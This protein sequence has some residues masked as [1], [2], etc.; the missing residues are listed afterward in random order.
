[1]T[2]LHK[3]SL[4]MCMRAL[5]LSE[6]RHLLKFSLFHSSLS[7]FGQLSQRITDGEASKKRNVFLHFWRLGSPVSRC[8]RI[9]CVGRACI[10]VHRFP[11]FVS[12]HGGKGKGPLWSLL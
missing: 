8:Q 6:W 9:P 5:S 1:M 7:L 3:C 11:S 4:A 12:S 10:L 2:L